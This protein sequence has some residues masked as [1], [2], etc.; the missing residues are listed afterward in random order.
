MLPMTQIRRFNCLSR[1]TWF[2]IQIEKK[3]EP[4][5]FFLEYKRRQCKFGSG[6]ASYHSAGSNTPLSRSPHRKPR[7]TG[8]AHDWTWM[9][10]VIKKAFQRCAG[11]VPAAIV[12]SQCTTSEWWLGPNRLVIP[13]GQTGINEANEWPPPPAGVLTMA[14]AEHQINWLPHEIKKKHTEALVNGH[15]LSLPVTLQL[16]NASVSSGLLKDSITSMTTSTGVP[17]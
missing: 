15:M 5:M 11:F 10:C 6:V 9:H 3:K 14:M 7:S 17:L 16:L 1:K 12:R 2:G 4:C 8:D 13:A